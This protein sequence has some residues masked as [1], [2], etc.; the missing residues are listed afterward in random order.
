MKDPSEIMAVIEQCTE[1]LKTAKGGKERAAI[2]EKL[3]DAYW[4]MDKF[5]KAKVCFKEALD[6][7]GENVELIDKFAGLLM[8]AGELDEATTFI[9]QA[10]D[11][12]TSVLAKARLHARMSTLQN[13]MGDF[14]DGKRD[15]ELALGLLNTLE[16]G[17]KDVIEAMAMATN[18]IGINLWEMSRYQEAEEKFMTALSI[19]DE[20]Q[21]HRGVATVMN[22]LGLMLYNTG[23][24]QGALK[25][26][27]DA[28]AAE[29]KL[30]SNFIT[31]TLFNNI[32]TV[33]MALGDL[34]MAEYCFE[35]AMKYN[36]SMNFKYGVHFS[37]LSLAD[38]S[39]EKCDWAKCR[40]WAD[41]AIMGFRAI[42]DEPRTASVMCTMAKAALGEGNLEMAERLGNSAYSMAKKN[43]SRWTEAHAMRVLGMV[44]AAKKD[45][46]LAEKVLK[47]SLE[48]F[49][50]MKFKYEL[51]RGLRA[52]AT[53][54]KDQGNTEEARLTVNEARGIAKQLGAKLELERLGELGF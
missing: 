48:I 28:K 51:A 5:E 46:A 13:R 45:H 35:Q 23:D 27:D 17:N 22:N 8:Q 29:E 42:K 21:D 16:R 12:T 44:A 39:I 34:D 15:G 41:R 19:Y 47:R 31:G 33:R 18:A 30:S 14:E 40:R 37:Q 9:E 26:F 24:L 32:G 54:Y 7:G 11:R 43:R 49:R 10:L 6:S 3:G 1:A 50:V 53:V 52:L 25:A 38:L 36:Q 2:F 20:L 4:G